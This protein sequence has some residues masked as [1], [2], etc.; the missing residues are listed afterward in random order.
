MLSLRKLTPIICLPGFFA[1]A[2]FLTCPLPA[3]ENN[4]Q[5]TIVSPENS[6]FQFDA[7][8]QPRHVTR[9]IK[10]Q[11]DL[12]IAVQ[13]YVLSLQEGRVALVAGYHDLPQI[14]DSV[15]KQNE[16]LDGAVKGA[17][18][19]VVGEL[20]SSE[21]LDFDEVPG[22]RFSYRGTRKG[23]EIEARS[24]LV[25]N[26]KRVYQLS[27]VHLADAEIDEEIAKR[28]FASFKLVQNK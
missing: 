26:G 10:P 27:V 18:V 4:L 6:G 21:Q 16:V 28:F 13:M 7:P 24:Q 9:Q 11:P 17:V 15:K 19:N 3:Q 25:L 5:W 20:N 12:E 8:G 22:R 23:R 14:P 1:L 2:V